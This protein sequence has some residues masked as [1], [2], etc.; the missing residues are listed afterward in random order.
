MKTKLPYFMIG[1]LT[2]QNLTIHVQL[3]AV[4]LRLFVRAAATD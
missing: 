2:C 4:A 1:T 3:Q